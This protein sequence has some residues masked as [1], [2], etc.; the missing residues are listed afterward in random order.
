MKKNFKI[1]AL[2]LVL[3]VALSVV[4]VACDNGDGDNG[5]NGGNS[6]IGGNGNTPDGNGDGSTNNGGNTNDSTDGGSGNTGDGGNTNGGTTND[7]GNTDGGDNGQT[8]NIENYTLDVYGINDM[9]GKFEDTNEQPGVDEMTT[10]LKNMASTQNT[11]FLSAGD[12]WQ[13]SCES[14]LTKGNIITEWMNELDFAAMTLGNHEFDWGV[15]PILD[16]IDLAEF[17][18]LAINVYDEDTDERLEGCEAST[19]IDLGSVQIGIIGAIGDCYGDISAERVEGEVYFKTDDELTALVME[20]S[21]RLR[22]EEG[23]DF[24]IYAIH[25]G[26]GSS[27]SSVKTMYGNLENEEGTYYDIDLSNGYVDLVFEGHSHQSYILKD[28][29]GVYHL[30]GGGD[31]SKGIT[32]AQVVF[33]FKNDEVTVEA[34]FVRHSAYTN[35]QDDAIVDELMEKYDD[36]VGAMYDHLGANYI[37]NIGKSALAETA[38]M[39]YYQYGVEKWG[40]E[41]DII[42]GGG[43]INVRSPGQ[44]TRGSVTYAQLYMLFPFDNAIVLCK[45]KGSDLKRRY[46]NN[47]DYVIYGYDNR[48]IVDS[49][50]YYIVTD[51]YNLYYKSN[52][53]TLVEIYGEDIYARDFLAQ[54]A[55]EGG[56][57]S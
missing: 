1:I 24:V 2:I 10:Y 42:I 18:I 21:Q 8:G 9:H 11:V 43:K 48:T 32:H 44:L 45:I 50:Y 4:L 47:R 6:A 30:Q 46:I 37:G 7:G 39:L 14:G 22:T 52:K 41:Y 35:L 36:E 34:G 28:S 12:M 23:V 38:A 57:E 17:P 16:N 49:E 29:F 20:E 53:L 25:D 54:Y 31:N 40:D 19:V 55:R 13:G 3:V 33:D 51:T 26:Y 5:G 27:S 56:F 15:E